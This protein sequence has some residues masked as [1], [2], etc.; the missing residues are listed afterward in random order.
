[1]KKI[2]G[3]AMVWT[4]WAYI[5]GLMQIGL[6]YLASLVSPIK[7]PITTILKDG[8]LFFFVT[9]MSATLMLDYLFS[10]IQ[11]PNWINAT[12][13]AVPFV[14]IILSVFLYGL[15]LNTDIE[16]VRIEVIRPIEYA[17]LS[18]TG[19]YSLVVKSIIFST[20]KN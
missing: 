15:F 6:L 7:F 1:M 12:L 17:I 5:F 8:S 11:I 14:L 16:N 18:T 20:R 3:C 13:I 4:G 9:A 10:K 2:I 19:I